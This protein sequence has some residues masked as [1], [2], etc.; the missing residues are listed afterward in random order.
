MRPTWRVFRPNVALAA[1]GLVAMDDSGQVIA[2]RTT[3]WSPDGLYVSVN[4]TD[5]LHGTVPPD[6]VDVIVARAD[7]ALRAVVGEDGAPVVTR[8]WQVGGVDSLGRGGAVG[9]HLYY[10]T[11]PGYAWSRAMT[12]PAAASGRVGADHGFPSIAADMYTAFCAIGPAIRS[13]RLPAA[14][15]IDVAPTVSAWLAMPAPRHARGAIV[16]TM[17]A[18]D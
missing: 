18:G 11:A 12:G 6:S 15:T 10:E 1:A 8:T 14:R 17:V 5:W 4:T 7:S 16:E 9:G 13:R 3:A 2:G